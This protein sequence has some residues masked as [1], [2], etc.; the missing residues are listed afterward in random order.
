MGGLNNEGMT[1]ERL[2]EVAVL[3]DIEKATSESILTWV[4]IT[5]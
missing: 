3:K 1:D 5:R 4:C 2:R